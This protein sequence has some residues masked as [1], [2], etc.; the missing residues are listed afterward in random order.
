MSVLDMRS[1]LLISVLAVVAVNAVCYYFVLHSLL[2]SVSL[3]TQFRRFG[4]TIK[5]ERTAPGD[6]RS[7]VIRETIHN[8][9]S[10]SMS[11]RVTKTPAVKKH[12]KTTD[13]QLKSPDPPSLNLKTIDEKT[14]DMLHRASLLV[15]DLTLSPP[16]CDDDIYLLVIVVSTPMHFNRR[17]EMRDSLKVTRLF[18]RGKRFRIVFLTARVDDPKTDTKLRNESLVYNDIIQ[19][20]SREAYRNL[21]Y[22]AL[23]SL[24]WTLTKCPHVKF[25]LKIDDDVLVI[26]EH[27]IDY[28]IGLEA[29]NATFVY[30][31]LHN[32]YPGPNRNAKSKWYLS[33]EDYKNNTL[34][35]FVCGFAALFSQYAV[36]DIYHASFHVPRVYSIPR[37]TFPQDDAFFGICAKYAKIKLTKILWMCYTWSHVKAAVKKDKCA[38]LKL[39]AVHGVTGYTKI[40]QYLELLKNMTVVERETC[41][42]KAIPLPGDCW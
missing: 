33:R 29:K 8:T 38:M 5:M 14:A 26:Y 9:R 19:V 36:R 20:N 39:Q 16:S 1:L 37:Q 12:F 32:L 15:D 35:P 27:I 24:R 30:A 13:S 10:T 22:K 2:N 40:K 25:M 23:E 41:E 34:P 7:N 3:R 42:K 11:S 28:A 31:G 4:E 21:T 17:A 18:D 6:Y